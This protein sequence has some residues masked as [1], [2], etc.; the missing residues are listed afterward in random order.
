MATDQ[1]PLV[2]VAGATASGKS[3]LGVALAQRLAEQGRPGEIINADS[4]QL[5]RGMD[6]GTAKITAEEMQGV[7]HHLLDVLDITEEAS[8]AAFQQQ[9]REEIGAIR[10]RGNT[11]VMVGGSGLY[12]RAATDVI[13]FP[14]TDPQLRSDLTQQ[15]QD[16]GAAALREE[17]RAADPE[18]ASVIKDDRRLVRALEVVRLTGRTFSSYMPQRIYEPSLGEIIQLGLSLPREQLHDRIARRVD[19]MAEQ[20][21]LEEVRRLD[22]QGLRRGRTASRAIGY[23]QH[24]QVLDGELTEAEALESTTV[25]T[26]KFARRQ[27][28]WFRADHRLQRISGVEEALE[29]IAA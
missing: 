27:E 13:E 26:R 25:A 24:L 14:P 21:L 1:T 23:Q 10:A 4:M 8:V 18:S 11:A 7:P 17:L 5:Y 19:L 6:I 12:I 20:G 15:L 3:A 29:A 28:T 2:V 16:Q 22:Q 9:A